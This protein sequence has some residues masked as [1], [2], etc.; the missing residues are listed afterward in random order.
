MGRIYPHSTPQRRKIVPVKRPVRSVQAPKPVLPLRSSPPEPERTEPPPT[1]LSIMEKGARELDAEADNARALYDAQMQRVRA[2]DDDAIHRARS[3]YNEYLRLRKESLDAA[4]AAAPFNHAKFG[5]QDP[6]ASPD[7][8]K[9]GVTRQQTIAAS[10]YL[11]QPYNARDAMAAYMVLIEGTDTPTDDEID[12][13]LA[14]QSAPT[15]RRF[16]PHVSYATHKK[17]ADDEPELEPQRENLT[18]VKFA[19]QSDDGADL[20]RV[21]SAP[22]PTRRSFTEDDP[23]LNDPHLPPV[24]HRE[25]AR[26]SQSL[27]DWAKTPS[28]R[29]R[30]DQMPDARSDLRTSVSASDLAHGPRSAAPASPFTD[31]ISYSDRREGQK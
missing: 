25:P 16:T 20:T 8:S 17:H 5:P 4:Q 21:K 13:E 6:D 10:A 24:Q 14:R 29:D 12:A 9:A 1:M 27:M 23:A 28:R 11:R 26:V 2:G 3:A 30:L 7:Q 31:S 18:R 19:P 15:P 22:P